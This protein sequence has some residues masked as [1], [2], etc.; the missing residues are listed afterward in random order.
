MALPTEPN[1]RWHSGRLGK[2]YAM[3]NAKKGRQLRFASRPPP[4]MPSS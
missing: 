4:N 3:R 2:S 1:E